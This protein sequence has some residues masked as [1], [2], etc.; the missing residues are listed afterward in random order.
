[1][2]L[3]RAT[4]LI[5]GISKRLGIKWSLASKW[6][7]EAEAALAC[8]IDGCLMYALS[9]TGH[10]MYCPSLSAKVCRKVVTRLFAHATQPFVCRPTWSKPSSTIATGTIVAE[11]SASGALR[12]RDVVRSYGGSSKMLIKWAGSKSSRLVGKV[13]PTAI[14][15]P[16][17][18]AAVR[19]AAKVVQD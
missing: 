16:L 8:G 10:V 14:K 11:T 1:M 13:V 17:K 3:G 9:S 6:K 19:L 4:V 18:K 7:A 12:F 15:A 5:K 2:L